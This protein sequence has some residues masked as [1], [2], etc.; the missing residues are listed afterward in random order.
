LLTQG[1]QVTN[2]ESEGHSELSK[3]RKALTTCE[4]K[5]VADEKVARDAMKLASSKLQV[6][7]VAAARAKRV[8][9]DI[10]KANTDTDDEH[11]VAVADK[12]AEVKTVAKTVN[13]AP[14]KQ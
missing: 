13:N 14:A 8:A 4:V 10:E 7:D 9:E 11:E 5:T 1:K 2:D 6:A 12:P 3:L